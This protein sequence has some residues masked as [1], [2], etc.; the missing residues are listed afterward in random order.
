MIGLVAASALALLAACS[1]TGAAPLSDAV[2]AASSPTTL[3][4]SLAGPLANVGKKTNKTKNKNKRDKK[5]KK[6]NKK[7]NGKKHKKKNNNTPTPSP[8]QQPQ[9]TQQPTPTPTTEVPAAPGADPVRPP[10]GSRILWVNPSTGED[11]ASGSEAAPLRTVAEA[12]RRIPMGTALTQPVW[13][14]LRAGVYP[15]SN[16]PHYWEDRRGTA[17]APIVLASADGA[18]AAVLRGDINAFQV[19]HLTLHGVAIDRSGDTF[20][21]ERCSY[22]T[23]NGVRLSGRGDAHETVKVNQSDHITIVNS[24]IS[25]AYENAIDFVA[26]QHSA[27]QNNTISD[28]GD[29]CAYVKGGSAYALVSGNRIHHCGTGG[30]TAGQ[31][32]GFEFMVPPWLGY[33]TYGVTVV[34]NIIHDTEGAGL[35]VNGGYNTVMAHNTMYRVGAR[36]HV[37]EFVHGSRSCDGDT[38]GC[39]RHRSLGGWGGPGID[40]QFIP[41]RH[42]YFLNNVVFNPP[43]YQSQWQHFQLAEPVN[44]PN[45]SGALA[46]ARVDDDLV[47][48]GNVISNGGGGMS[49]GLS[50]S[51]ERTVLRDN[52]INSLVPDLVDPA[53]GDFRPRGGGALA[54]LPSAGLPPMTWADVGVPAG[55]IPSLPANHPPGALRSS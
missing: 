25:G 29:W 23:L 12:W 45:G 49:T 52:R 11:D 1:L 35:G 14:M 7:A 34:N 54:G 40:A 44:P 22:V 16:T 8:S 6:K 53:G 3:S 28:A 20:H 37:V 15:E 21:C 24:S 32:T 26:V 42:T 30:F 41:S 17:A 5:A 2:K 9:P 18:G 51:W 55:T 50:D 27:I 4:S 31:G 48:V 33:E 36:S 10:A 38:A 19:S 47:I 46:P 13:V 43:G 39:Q